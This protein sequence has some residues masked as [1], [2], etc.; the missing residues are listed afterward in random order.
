M[1]ESISLV[2]AGG[3][4][5]GAYQI[6][7]CKAFRDIGLLPKLQYI[8]AA[9]IGTLNAYSLATNK[10]DIAEKM[11]LNTNANCYHDFFNVLIR[12]SVIFDF[13]DGLCKEDDY[14]KIP[15]YTV[16]WIPPKI[17]ADYIDLS[18]EIDYQKRLKLLKAAISFPPLMK[19]VKIDGKSVYDGA[20]IENVPINPPISQKVDLLI[21]VQFEDYTWQIGKMF[22][23]N[24]LFLNL[25]NSKEKLLSS[26]SVDKQSVKNMIEYGYEYSFNILN[27][28][29]E[30]DKNDKDL[31]IIISLINQSFKEKQI[32]GDKMIRRMNRI[33]KRINGG[34]AE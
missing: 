22:A 7:F 20:I 33:M 31:A 6:G 26:F 16:H 8:S 21:V 9:S 13:V 17:S 10:I 5:K 25:D 1:I 14:L 23:E 15:L 24:V 12:K 29:A 30:S 18:R 27:L 28:L 4:A 11:W 19:P 2:F 3:M 34:K 32:S